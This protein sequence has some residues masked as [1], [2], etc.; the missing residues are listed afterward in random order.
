MSMTLEQLVDAGFPE[1]NFPEDLPKPGAENIF[2]RA[3]DNAHELWRYHINHAA[4]VFAM[5]I[6]IDRS[7]ID[8]PAEGVGFMLNQFAYLWRT[9]KDQL[10]V[11]EQGRCRR[12]NF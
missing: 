11:D 12:I 1:E 10:R 6:V 2:S 3:M 9:N 8:D 5:E 7:T 4:G